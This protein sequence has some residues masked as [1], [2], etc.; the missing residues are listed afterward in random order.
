MATSH[1]AGSRLLLHYLLAYSVL[2]L[3]FCYF[4]LL[5]CLAAAELTALTAPECA[6]LVCSAAMPTAGL[7]M[8]LDEFHGRTQMS[9]A[10]ERRI[11]VCLC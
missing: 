5:P 6:S 9:W 2:Y 1:G 3:V 7:A 8:R 11:N 10:T 4:L